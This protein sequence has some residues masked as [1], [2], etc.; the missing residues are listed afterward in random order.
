MRITGTMNGQPF[1]LSVQDDYDLK[2][3]NELVRNHVEAYA[4][5]HATPLREDIVSRIATSIVN[6]A[7]IFDD[8]RIGE[9]ADRDDLHVAD[10]GIPPPPPAAKEDA[11]DC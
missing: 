11:N 3:Q 4:S 7:L 10:A 1:D 2:T 9:I 6:D 5:E 8:I